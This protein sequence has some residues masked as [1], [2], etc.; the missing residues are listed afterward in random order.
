MGQI[1]SHFKR[2]CIIN[3]KQ[4]QCLDRGKG[5]KKAAIEEPKARR[6]PGSPK[7]GLEVMM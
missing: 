5:I 7:L 6:K 3:K 2:Y 1:K 4:I